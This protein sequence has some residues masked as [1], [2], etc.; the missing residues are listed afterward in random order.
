MQYAPIAGLRLRVS[1]DK[2]IRAP[3]VIELYNP[4]LVGLIQ[5][6]NDPC[7]PP[8][9]CPASAVRQPGRLGRSVRGSGGPR[10]G[11]TPSRSAAGQCSQL[12]GGNPALK[13]EQAE[14]YTVG[15]NFPPSL[16][17]QFTGSLDY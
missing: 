10:C 16:L 7:A 11:V 12:T 3:S 15:V 5:S 4:Q 13:P 14:T 17:P 6:G 9:T 2:A 1:Y 8:V